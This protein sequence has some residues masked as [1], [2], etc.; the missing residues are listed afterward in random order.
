M[1]H[2]IFKINVLMIYLN[3]LINLKSL[4]IKLTRSQLRIITKI[5]NNKCYQHVT[6]IDTQFAIVKN[7]DNSDLLSRYGL[8]PYLDVKSPAAVSRHS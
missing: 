4:T 8:S 6:G 5:M 7:L 3:K 1:P 2:D